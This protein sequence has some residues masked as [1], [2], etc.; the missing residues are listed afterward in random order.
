MPVGDDPTLQ[1]LAWSGDIAMW[2]AGVYVFKEAA[3]LQEVR[4]VQ[5]RKRTAT[6]VGES[7]VLPRDTRRVP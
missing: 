6:L 7:S 2:A 1:L 3:L 5:K 4:P